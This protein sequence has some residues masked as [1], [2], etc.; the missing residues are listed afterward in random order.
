[1]CRHKVK[2]ESFYAHVEL[3][4]ELNGSQVTH[5]DASITDV[6]DLLTVELLP[7]LAVELLNKRND[8]LWSD[9]V[10]E[11]VA[12]IALVL[13]INRQVEEVIGATELVING[14]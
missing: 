3:C 5:L 13:E 4:Q 8:I 9:H 7:F 6:A 12:D 1:M 11:G 2:M 14:G 10:D